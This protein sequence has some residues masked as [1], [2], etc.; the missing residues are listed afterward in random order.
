MKSHDFSIFIVQK[1]KR[2]QT[3]KTIENTRADYE[4]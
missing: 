2:C 4:I 3:R 1:T